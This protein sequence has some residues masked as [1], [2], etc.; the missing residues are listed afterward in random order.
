MRP[1]PLTPFQILFWTRVTR[2]RLLRI[3]YD[4]RSGVL[5]FAGLADNGLGLE[6]AAERNHSSTHKKQRERSGFRNC[7][8]QVEVVN[9]R[10]GAESVNAEADRFSDPRVS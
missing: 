8:H 3:P 10:V 6:A 5:K 9:L 4:L 7:D 2:L 1:D